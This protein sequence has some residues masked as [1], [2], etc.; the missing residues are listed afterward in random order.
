MTHWLLKAL[1]VFT[2]T[3]VV[4]VFWTAYTRGVS[5]GRSQVAALNSV[6]IV[7][8]GS[9]SIFAYVSDASMVIPA[10]AGAYVGTLIGMRRK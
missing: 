6:A 4:D 7:G 8:L 9:I 1:A 5:A 10:M 2:A 3:A